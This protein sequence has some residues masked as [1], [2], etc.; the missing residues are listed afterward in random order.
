SKTELAELFGV[1]RHRI[2]NLLA[3]LSKAGLVCC[4]FVR[5]HSG[6]VEICAYDDVV[7][8]AGRPGG[9]EPRPGMHD[10]L[11]PRGTSARPDGDEARPDGDEAR[12]D[13]DERRAKTLTEGRTIRISR[14]EISTQRDD[15]AARAFEHFGQHG[16]TRDD[17]VRM[18]DQLRCED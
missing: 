14:G 17:C 2:S 4:H 1:S 11:V 18:I 7:H 6:T 16:A 5:G 3:V 9:D 13:E 15:L 10:R 8:A 12:P